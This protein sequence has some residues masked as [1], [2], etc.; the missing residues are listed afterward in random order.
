MTVKRGM[1]WSDVMAVRKDFH[2]VESGC[3]MDVWEGEAEG[4][5]A[6]AV[7][8]VDGVVVDLE[9]CGWV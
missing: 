3:G 7:Y 8:V 5:G 6:L 9:R 4:D 1:K 2:F